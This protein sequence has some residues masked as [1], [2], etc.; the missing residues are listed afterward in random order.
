MLLLENISRILL[1]H[2]FTLNITTV[3]TTKTH[4]VG[5]LPLNLAW[6]TKKLSGST[7]GPRQNVLA[8]AI[9][10]R[11]SACITHTSRRA[12]EQ[13]AIE[14]RIERISTVE[15]ARENRSGRIHTAAKPSN[16]HATRT[17]TAVRM[18]RKREP[19]KFPVF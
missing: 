14:K 18:Q 4:I 17:H 9:P 13:K 7:T 8:A 10:C 1:A 11:R 2:I 6:Y 19:T 3:G 12:S 15:K 16:L 5:T